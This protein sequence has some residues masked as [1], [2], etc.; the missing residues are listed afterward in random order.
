[1]LLFAVG[2]HGFLLSTVCV[3]SFTVSVCGLHTGCESKILT[4]VNREVLQLVLR[5]GNFCDFCDEIS[6]KKKTLVA[7]GV[8]EVECFLLFS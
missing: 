6:H 8:C 4:S 1:M 2:V 5:R 7:H 3:D